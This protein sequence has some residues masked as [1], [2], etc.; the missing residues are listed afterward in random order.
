ME[1]EERDW[2]TRFT[3]EQ[4][5]RSATV[6]LRECLQAL[7]RRQRRQG[8]ASGRRAA[9]MALNAVLLSHA[10]A[11]WGRSYVDHLRAVS[12]D[13]RV[14]EVVRDS[15]KELLEASPEGPALIRIGA[16][17]DSLASAAATVIDWAQA[18]LAGEA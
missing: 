6:E 11:S 8:V 9:G 5:M 14:P 7:R 17:D 12:I 15:A 3:A 1:T 16:A 2:L 18:R 10:D 13:D 4:W